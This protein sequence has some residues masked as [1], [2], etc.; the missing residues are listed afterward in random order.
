MAQWTVLRYS[1]GNYVADKN[2]FIIISRRKKMLLFLIIDKVLF[3]DMCAL[4]VFSRVH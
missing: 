2:L 3:E 4:Y 1:H